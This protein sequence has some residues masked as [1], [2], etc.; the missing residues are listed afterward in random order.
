MNRKTAR[1]KKR[2]RR[3]LRHRDNQ[4]EAWRRD[5]SIPLEARMRRAT[6]NPDGSPNYGGALVISREELA[7]CKAILD[8]MAPPA[9][10]VRSVS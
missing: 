4:S 3:Q 1:V 9:D 2:R 7:E 10:I 6:T 5:R 8:R